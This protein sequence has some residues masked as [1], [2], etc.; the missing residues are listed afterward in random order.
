MLERPSVC[1]RPR[2]DIAGAAEGIGHAN[3]EEI[4]LG[5]GNR[6]PR[7]RALIGRELMPDQSVFENLVVLTYRARRQADVGRDGGEVDLLAACE[8]RRVQEPAEIAD[9]P[10]QA[11]GLDLLAQVGAD[12]RLQVFREFRRVEDGRQTAAIESIEH[13]PVVD[14]RGCE[15]VQ[16]GHAGASAK[17]VRATPLQ[18]ARAAPGQNKAQRPVPLDE[19]MNLVEQRWALLDLV[20]DDDPPGWF[21]RL[22]QVLGAC[23]QL[24]VGVG[25]Q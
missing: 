23:R 19:Q 3:V 8:P 9:R 22:S 24:A 7:A 16:P 15:G 17:Q 13:P 14:L 5:G 11:L 6:F 18:L 25:F 10:G 1:V 20:Y 2:F 4:E 12:T 21:Q